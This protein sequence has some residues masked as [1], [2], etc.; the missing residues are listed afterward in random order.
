M[1]TEG[2]FIDVVFSW[3]REDTY[4]TKKGGQINILDP[5]QVWFFA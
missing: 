1:M 2:K 4:S 5:I 3:K